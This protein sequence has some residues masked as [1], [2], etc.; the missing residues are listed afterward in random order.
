MEYF[1]FVLIFL[2]CSV[3]FVKSNKNDANLQ[4]VDKQIEDLKNQLKLHDKISGSNAEKAT[5]WANLGLNLQIKDVGWH[6]GGRDLQPEA[7]DCFNKALLLADSSDLRLLMTVNQHKGIL[8]KM[9]DRGEES[10]EAHDLVFELSTANYDKSSALFS[11]GDALAML[12]RIEEAIDCY[13]QALSLRPDQISTY[14]PLVKSLKEQNKMSKSNWKSL[15]K[16]MRAELKKV[17]RGEYDQLE[18]YGVAV[19]MKDRN[20]E[21][22]SEIYWALFEV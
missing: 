3:S 19:L 16:E 21:I 10:A 5:A 20:T 9:M 22:T 7:L 15:L 14:L 18:E 4:V 17:L 6:V 8:L 12:G 11:K 13:R 1:R 2:F